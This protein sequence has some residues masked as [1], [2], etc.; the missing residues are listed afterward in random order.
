[1]TL[2]VLNMKSLYRYRKVLVGMFVIALAQVACS[3]GASAL[4][5]GPQSAPSTGAQATGPAAA[6][7][8]EHG[9]PE[10]AKAMLQKAIEHYSAVGRT[11]ALADFTGRV[12]PFFVGDLYVACIDSHLVISANGGFPNLVGTTTEPLSRAAWDAASKTQISSVNYSYTD[13]VTGKT[14]PKT[15][16]YERVGSDV[17]GVGVYHP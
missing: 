16:Y 12:A 1:M 5:A 13:P 11:Q 6:V 3:L 4:P 14:Q 8:A 9:T 10:Q 17:C 2:E 7:T 15:L